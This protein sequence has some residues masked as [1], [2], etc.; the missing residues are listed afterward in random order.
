MVGTV[1]PGELTSPTARAAIIGRGGVRFA[2]ATRADDAA[3]RRLLRDNPMRGAISLSFEREPDY[4]RGANLAGAEDRTIVA[5]ENERLLC[6]GRCS[7]R[8]CWVNGRVQRVGYLAELRLDAD[9]QGRFDILRGGYEFFRA[10]H[11]AAPADCYFTSIAA[12]N[13]RARRLFERGVRGLPRYEFLTQFST[14]LI[15]TG[16]KRPPALRLESATTTELAAFLDAHASTR[17]LAAAWS[18]HTITHLVDSA[19]GLAAEHFGVVRERGQIVACAAL[20][21]Q[22]TWRQTVVRG[23]SRPLALGRPWLNFAARLTGAPRL[24]APGSVLA[25]ALLSSQAIAPGH[26]SLLPDFIATWSGVAAARGIEF[27]TLGFPSS[28][29]QLPELRRRFSARHYASRI[30]AVRWPGDDGTPLDRRPVS[31]DIAFL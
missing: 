31:P 15:P 13:D 25:H 17:N 5:F 20:W 29:P 27:L 18:A 8:H 22:R 24:P 14:L 4:F 10:L 2:L 28:E 3:I 16:A 7:T 12:D 6:M 19:S 1:A 9:A 26:E 11:R 21:D 30:Y 23:Y